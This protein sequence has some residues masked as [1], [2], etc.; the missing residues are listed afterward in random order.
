MV[1]RLQKGGDIQRHDAAHEGGEG[2]DDRGDV[3]GEAGVV[4]EG[5]EHDADALAAIDDAETV[6][7]DDEK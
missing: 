6:E 5:V 1:E 4:E 3:D 2:E 7:G